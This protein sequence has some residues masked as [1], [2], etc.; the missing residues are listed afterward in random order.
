MS[1][2]GLGLGVFTLLLCPLAYLFTW[3]RQ[4]AGI[5]AAGVAFVIAAGFAGAIAWSAMER[6]DK[7]VEDYPLESLEPRLAYEKQTP[8][9]EHPRVELAAS[10]EARVPPPEKA[11]ITKRL[12]ELPSSGRIKFDHR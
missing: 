5:A 3:G 8:Q 1:P 11:A 2:F 6:I 4:G 9:A 10:V 12:S 7:L